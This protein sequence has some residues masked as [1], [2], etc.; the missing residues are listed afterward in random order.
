MN[1]EVELG[2]SPEQLG[3]DLNTAGQLIRNF[4]NQA[5]RI[6]DVGDKLSSLGQKLTAGITLPVV[7]LGA[8]SV[9]A[10]GDIQAL[11]KV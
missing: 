8:A 3:R 7:G 2:A 6:G 1:L 10:Y 11:Q 4:V 9:K 5:E